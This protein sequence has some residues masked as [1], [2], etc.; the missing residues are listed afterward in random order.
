[1]AIEDEAVALF[2]DFALW[3]PTAPRLRGKLTRLARSKLHPTNANT[4]YAVLMVEDLDHVSPVGACP[5]GAAAR[6]KF[7]S[8]KITE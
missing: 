3:A 7:L 8:A 2:V 6:R 4:E 5:R 1:M